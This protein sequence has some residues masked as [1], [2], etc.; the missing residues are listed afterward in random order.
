MEDETPP[1]A[2]RPALLL[3]TSDCNEGCIVYDVRLE[4]VGSGT[5]ES[6]L[7]PS[8]DPILCLAASPDHTNYTELAAVSG[9]ATIV[10]LV[11]G[12]PDTLVHDL[13]TEAHTPG[14]R[15][16]ASK[17]RP[18]MLPV[19]DHTVLV[20]NEVLRPGRHCFEALRRVPSA[21]GDT[22]LADALPDPPIAYAMD[23]DEDDMDDDEDTYHP[24]VMAYFAIGSRAWISVSRVGTLSLDMDHGG[25]SWQVEGTWELPLLGRGLFVPELGVVV[26]IPA[27]AH[28][29][30]MKKERCYQVCA[31]DVEARPPVVRRKWGIPPERVEE[32]P[33]WE[34]SLAH[35]GN[36]RLCVARSIVVKVPHHEGGLCEARGTSF[37]LVDV[38]RRSPGG[39]LELARHGK[40]HGHTT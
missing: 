10:S 37:T 20:M 7:R 40:V 29:H 21:G 6:S 2:T 25:A 30:S 8:M 34:V 4:A 16:R 38:R 15:L 32:V 11:A 19:G 33:P 28:R 35:L 5:P 27:S 1:D 17:P 12:S 23:D 14:P 22:W 24:H 13:A 18:I 3:S 39:E 26:G 36:G 31:L 9:G